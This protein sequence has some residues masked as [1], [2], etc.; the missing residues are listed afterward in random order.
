MAGRAGFIE[1]G[2]CQLQDGVT[3]TS[4]AITDPTCSSPTALFL[5]TGTISG[6]GAI[7]TTIAAGLGTITADTMIGTTVIEVAGVMAAIIAAIGTTTTTIETG[8]MMGITMATMAI[9]VTMAIMV[10]TMLAVGVTTVT[11]MGITTATMVIVVT[12]MLTA[13]VTM[14]ITAITSE[15]RLV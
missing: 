7:A 4:M 14:A 5:E 1:S 3:G 11:M 12:I 8:T 6:V 2:I 15:S 10:T 13:V 9:V